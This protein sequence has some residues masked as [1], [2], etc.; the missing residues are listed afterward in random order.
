MTEQS[1]DDSPEEEPTDADLARIDRIKYYVDVL[2][3]QVSP[4]L[5]AAK[6]DE[7]SAADELAALAIALTTVTQIALVPFCPEDRR[8]IADAAI[9]LFGIFYEQIT[10]DMH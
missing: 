1:P 4:L 5:T 3:S 2:S 10:N 9:Q 6:E 7:D 8:G